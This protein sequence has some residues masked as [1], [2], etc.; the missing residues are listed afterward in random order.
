MVQK[1][2]IQNRNKKYRFAFLLL[3]FVVLFLGLLTLK[4]L[5]LPTTEA[6]L[7][8]VNIQNSEVFLTALRES[9]TN[10]GQVVLE[11]NAYLEASR[12]HLQARRSL[13]ATRKKILAARKARLSFAQ[14]SEVIRLEPFKESVRLAEKD[15]E[16]EQKRVELLEQE[17]GNNEKL[18]VNEEQLLLNDESMVRLAEKELDLERIK[19]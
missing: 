8:E 16:G 19:H 4:L 13:L 15:V 14:H 5:G 12:R 18:V 17:V 10:R 7:R 3:I 2:Q 9:V 11:M 6:T 1:S